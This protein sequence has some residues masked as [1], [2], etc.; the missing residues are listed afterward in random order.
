MNSDFIKDT[1]H[2]DQLL[3]AATQRLIN[4]MK[5][6]AERDYEEW[7]LREILRS[8][9]ESEGYLLRYDDANKFELFELG[10]GYRTA[11]PY[12]E[13]STGNT[14]DSVSAAYCWVFGGR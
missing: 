13:R 1:K 7:N 10:G 12:W 2:A 5:S 3:A 11:I 4:T 14:F 9:L 8:E 6:E